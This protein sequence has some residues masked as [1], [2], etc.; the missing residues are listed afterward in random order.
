MFFNVGEYDKAEEYYEN[1]LAIRIET[2]DRKGEATDYGNLGNVFLRLG[3]F[4]KA[5][6]Y[7][8]KAIWLSKKLGFREVELVNQLH[9]A[10][11]LLFEGDV[12]S[13]RPHLYQT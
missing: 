12:D 4:A 9:L 11:L 3:K 10:S 13:A 2:Q 7:F 5:K 1:A 8:E 6:K